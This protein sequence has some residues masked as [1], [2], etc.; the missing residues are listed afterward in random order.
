FN[1]PGSL[2][3]S[4][5]AMSLTGPVGQI[6]GS[7]LTGGSWNVSNGASLI[8]PGAAIA[9]NMGAIGIGGATSTFDAVAGLRTNYGAFALSNGKAFSTAQ[10][11]NFGKLSI[12]PGSIFTITG[13]FSNSFY[14]VSHGGTINASGGGTSTGPFWLFSSGQ[15]NLGGAHSLASTATI[16]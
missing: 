7:T 16:S 13:S 4:G 3:V 10:F 12:G 14:A 8:I 6:S 5:G 15:V 1:N 11:S 9:I 2:T